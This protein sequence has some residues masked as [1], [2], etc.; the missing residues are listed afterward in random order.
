M[1]HQEEEELGLHMVK[2]AGTLYQHW[3]ITDAI[4]FPSQKLD[5]AE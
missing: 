1:K 4:Q 3:N 2:M 5:P